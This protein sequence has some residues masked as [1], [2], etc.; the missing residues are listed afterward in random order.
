M[1]MPAIVGTSKRPRWCNPVALAALGAAVL[2]AILSCP[3]SAQAAV[4]ATI[5]YEPNGGIGTT[6]S[7]RVGTGRDNTVRECMFTRPGYRFTGWKS[8]YDDEYKPSDVYYVNPQVDSLGYDELKAQW[9][10]ITPVLPG[11]HDLEASDVGSWRRKSEYVRTSGTYWTVHWVVTRDDGTTIDG[12][13]TSDVSAD[14]ATR[15]TRENIHVTNGTIAYDDPVEHRPTAGEDGYW[16]YQV[17]SPEVLAYA[18]LHGTSCTSGC[19]VTEGDHYTV[20][21]ETDGDTLTVVV[22]PDPAYWDVDHEPVR[23]TLPKRTSTL[24]ANGGS[25]ADG[26]TSRA[27]DIEWSKA[28][29]GATGGAVRTAPVAPY[30]A[31]K[32]DGYLVSGW[33]GKP[34]GSGGAYDVDSARTSG[35]TLYAQWQKAYTLTF[36]GTGEARQVLPGDAIGDLPTPSRDGYSLLGWYTEADGGTQVTS[37][38]TYDW[39]QDATLYP[40][41]EANLVLT[42]PTTVATTVLA[43]GT[44]V[45][46]SAE[47]TRIYNHSAVPVRI[48]SIE[49]T[50]SAGWRI[51]SEAT[52][53]DDTDILAPS[54]NGTTA[55]S[56]GDLPAN[57]WTL[58]AEGAAGDA[59]DLDISGRVEKVTH[60]LSRPISLMTID[61]R[62]ARVQ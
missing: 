3:R 56:L 43:D 49:I 53:A 17:E 58:A 47:S 40:H 1:A 27:Y 42:V 35:Q 6:V 44:I 2:L 51:A 61:Y 54:V 59:M 32:R 41:W 13:T 9:E 11:T 12:T 7:Q 31:P 23:V 62:F 30:E 50:P 16:E 4:A 8:L 60:D 55:E 5:Y 22:T 25:Y 39:D 10:K 48:A 45:A 28:D 52:A 24:D 14:D 33:N 19:E 57:G 37:E 18:S 29:G 34:D 26:A 36:D 38:T 46:P 21:T 15:M 20:G